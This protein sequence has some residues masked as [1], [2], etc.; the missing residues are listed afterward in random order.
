AD[1]EEATGRIREAI[2]ASPVPPGVAAELEQAYRKLGTDVFVAVRSSGTAEDLAEA[3][4]AGLHDTYLDVSG[5]DAVAHAV[6]LCWASMWTARAT[7]YRRTHGFDQ[8][9]ARLAVVVQRMVT[10]EAS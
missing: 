8:R 6:R 10:S 1:L 3:S 4:F 5:V 2:V 9:A 7:S